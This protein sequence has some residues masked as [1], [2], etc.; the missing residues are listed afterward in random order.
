MARPINLLSA[1]FVATTKNVGLH[2]DGGGL[3]LEVDKGGGKR[4]TF[5]WRTGGTRRQM[6]LGGILPTD[7]VEARE[8]ADGTRKQIARGLDP[9]AERK[10]ARA[11]GRTFG[12][13]ADAPSKALAPEWRNDNTRIRGNIAWGLWPRPSAPPC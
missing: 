5:T 1:R 4:W 13:A 9:I 12:E 6:G 7:L 3:Y 8:M 10:T 11:K 2:S